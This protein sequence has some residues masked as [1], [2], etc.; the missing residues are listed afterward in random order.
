MISEFTPGTDHA[1]IFFTLGIAAPFCFVNGNTF[2]S[3]KCIHFSIHI[4]HKNM[5]F[6]LKFAITTFLLMPLKCWTGTPKFFSDDSHCR[7]LIIVITLLMTQKMKIYSNLNKNSLISRTQIFWIVIYCSI[8]DWNRGKVVWKRMP[9]SV[10]RASLKID[11][12]HMYSW[13]AR[14]ILILIFVAR[15]FSPESRYISVVLLWQLPVHVSHLDPSIHVILIILTFFLMLSSCL[16]LVL[17][18]ICWSKGSS[19]CFFLITV[20]HINY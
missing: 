3:T 15:S 14:H 9:F 19:P 17:V 7:L 16:F 11:I 4:I 1:G 12:F 6:S 2:L 13:W 5:F 18:Y 10:G 20:L 8:V